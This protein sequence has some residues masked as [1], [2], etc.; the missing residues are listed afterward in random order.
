M[1][2]GHYRIMGIMVKI[3]ERPE[4]LVDK[5][6]FLIR[7]TMAFDVLLWVLKNG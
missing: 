4:R 7:T 6:S 5:W 2:D 3:V 1:A